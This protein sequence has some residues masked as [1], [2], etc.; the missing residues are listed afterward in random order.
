MVAWSVQLMLFTGLTSV[1]AALLIAV[2]AW[3]RTRGQDEETRRAF[4][5]LYMF[6]AAYLLFGG[7]FIYSWIATI[8]M[9]PYPTYLIASIIV[10]EM[11]IIIL[12][13]LATAGRLKRYLG[14]IVVWLVMVWLLIYWARVTLD[15]LLTYL[16][17]SLV[18]VTVFYAFYLFVPIA[19][20]AKRAISSAITVSLIM[21][22]LNIIVI[23]VPMSE[24]LMS[25][26]LAVALLGPCAVF[27]SLIRPSVVST[28]EILG[29]SASISTP[30]TVIAY[31]DSTG[32]WSSPVEASLL[33]VCAF[34]AGFAA[35]TSSFLYGRWSATR[36]LQTAL[37]SFATAV[38]AMTQFLNILASRPGILVLDIN[39]ALYI[40][41]YSGLFILTLFSVNAVM[42]AGW[43]RATLIPVL[44]A[45]PGGFVLYQIYPAPL[46]AASDLIIFYVI[47]IL[48]LLLL[49]LI[50]YLQVWYL[51]RRTGVA[52]RRALSISLYLILSGL[53]HALAFFNIV[54]L[55]IG[56]TLHALSSFILFLGITDELYRRPGRTKTAEART[57]A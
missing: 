8:F 15:P 24:I 7:S 47:S 25:M 4:R 29:S 55:L 49:P 46:F 44:V 35:R 56:N 3:R 12:A 37:F 57:T 19:R 45:I 53:A 52:G 39:D 14:P 50:I 18:G 16:C 20:A 31:I 22:F 33:I 30:I 5:I 28:L 38:I 9:V 34:G 13:I 2:Y 21:Q 51:S 27:F 17:M 54:E 42:A 32:V 10:L 40:E 26:L 43:S 11:D 1:T 41:Y 36:V 48:F 6:A 23:F